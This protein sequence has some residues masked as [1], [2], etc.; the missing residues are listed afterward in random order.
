[1]NTVYAINQEEIKAPGKKNIYKKS[2]AIELI[3]K[4]HDLSHTM[5]NKHNPKY[6]VFVFNETPSLISDLLRI[7]AI[8]A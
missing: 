2:L 8:T 6:Q 5:K 7:N 1:M 3:K 4:G